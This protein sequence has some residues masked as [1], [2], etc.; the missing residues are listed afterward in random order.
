MNGDKPAMFMIGGA[1]SVNQ[2][3]DSIYQRSVIDLPQQQQLED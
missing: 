2:D 3:D 1:D